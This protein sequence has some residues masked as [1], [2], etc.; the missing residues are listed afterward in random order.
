MTEK[1]IYIS[2]QESTSLLYINLIRL[3]SERYE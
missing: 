3:D 1:I 2:L